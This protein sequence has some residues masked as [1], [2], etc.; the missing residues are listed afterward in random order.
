MSLVYAN[1]DSITEEIQRRKQS[2]ILSS[3]FLSIGEPVAFLIKQSGGERCSCYSVEK[4]EGNYKCGLCYGIGWKDGYTIVSKSVDG[5]KELSIF[6]SN[7]AKGIIQEDVGQTV[8]AI[9]GF[10]TLDYPVLR[11]DDIVVRLGRNRRYIILDIT[12]VIIKGKLV[13]QSGRMKELEP[14]HMAYNISIQI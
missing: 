10:W 12:N 5:K 1:T 3:N 2:I 11:T 9:L 8:D 14:K 4:G 7:A 6:I 13:S